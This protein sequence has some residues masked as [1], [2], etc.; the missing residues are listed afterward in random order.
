MQHTGSRHC[1]DCSFPTNVE[2]IFSTE[3]SRSHPERPLGLWQMPTGGIIP[4][5][6]AAH[7]GQAHSYSMQRQRRPELEGTLRNLDQLFRR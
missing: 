2:R 3:K 1:V 5:R 7:I 4:P 6:H